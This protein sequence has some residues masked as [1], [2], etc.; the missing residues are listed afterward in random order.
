MIVV[1]EELVVNGVSFV[2]FPRLMMLR[3]SWLVW[4][5]SGRV[6]QQQHRGKGEQEGEREERER[7]G[8]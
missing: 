6:R 8:V 4:T 5:L 7:N 3:I 1:F 2:F